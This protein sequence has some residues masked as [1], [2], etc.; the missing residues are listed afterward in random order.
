MPFGFDGELINFSLSG[1][2]SN[3]IDCEIPEFSDF[4]ITQNND[5]DALLF[6]GELGYISIAGLGDQFHTDDNFS[7]EAWIKPEIDCSNSHSVFFLKENDTTVLSLGIVGH[8]FQM[9]YYSPANVIANQVPHIPLETE[10][11]YYEFIEELDWLH[12]V[13]SSDREANLATFYLNG[14]LIAENPFLPGTGTR[15]NFGLEMGQ[16]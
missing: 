7:F 6:E 9:K 5:C 8:Q 12:F 4:I 2:Y 3:W 11:F 14:R 13:L 10:V 1:V 15:P 16:L